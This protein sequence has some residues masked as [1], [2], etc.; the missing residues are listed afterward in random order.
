[1][2]TYR[3]FCLLFAG[4]LSAAVSGYIKLCAEIA[5]MPMIRAVCFPFAVIIGMFTGGRDITSGGNLSIAIGTPS[6]TGIPL[7]AA[8]SVFCVTHLGVF[9]VGRINR[10][11][12]YL[13]H[14]ADCFVHT[15]SFAAGVGCFINNIAAT[16]RLTLFPVA[17]FIGCPNGS[18]IV[19]VFS[20][21]LTFTDFSV[22][23]SAIGVPGVAF[24]VTGCFFLIFQISFADVVG[25]IIIACFKSFP[26]LCT[27]YGAAFVI[28]CFATAGGSSFQ[29]IRLY[30]LGII[31]G[32]KIAVLFMANIANCFLYTG[33]CTADM[34]TER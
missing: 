18:R 4:S 5:G 17:R 12:F 16:Y 11:V 3:A 34:I 9:M 32:C 13:A 31:V 15:G 1:M 24:I 22:T 2:P 14:R 19:S 33:C 10:T 20:D 25:I 23:S 29:I 30:G 6:V 28:N 27:T 7:L 8:G 21:R 26:V